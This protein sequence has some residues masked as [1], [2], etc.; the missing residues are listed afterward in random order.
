[1]IFGE[2]FQ[3]YRQQQKEIERKKRVARKMAKAN[4]KTYAGQLVIRRG[5]IY[6]PVK[7][8]R[9]PGLRGWLKSF[10]NRIRLGEG[11]LL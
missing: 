8:V 6:Q 11:R 4:R 10:W 9:R 3:E 2:K 1:M 7:L 5:S